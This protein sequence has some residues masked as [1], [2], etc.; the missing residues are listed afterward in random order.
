MRL[1]TEIVLSE[2]N[3]RNSGTMKTKEKVSV[4]KKGDRFYDS[5]RQNELG[6]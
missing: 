5:K 3:E 6:K 4:L 1:G 2:E